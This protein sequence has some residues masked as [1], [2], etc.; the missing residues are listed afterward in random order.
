MMTVASLAYG[1]SAAR[2][3]R[4]GRQVERRERV[5][6]EVD[7]RL[8]H[9]RPRH[10]EALALTARHVHAALRDL[11]VEPSR[12]RPHEVGRLRDLERGPQLVLGGVRLAVA[13]VAGD[14]AR[15]QV[16]L[17]RDDADAV[18]EDVRIEFADV[19]AVEQDRARRDV[20]EARG[21]VDQARL[22]RSGAP[23]DGRRLTGQR[24]ERDVLEDGVLG[25]G[26][27]ESHVAQ[28]EP[29]ALRHL[30]DRSARA[31]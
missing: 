31:A 29:S 27:A 3:L 28:L 24:G 16:R 15:E 14:G 21:H 1:T 26:I 25:A 4:V 18:P 5:V 19:D 13:Q 12:H 30:G 10:G 8:A 23:D 11:G 6:E 9:E 7:L 2:N 20:E 17:L 22:A